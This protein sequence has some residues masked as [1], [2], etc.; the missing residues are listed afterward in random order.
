MAST[1][2]VTAKVTAINLKHRKATFQF[3]DGSTRTVA[4]RKD[5]D[6]SKRQVGEEVVIRTTETLAIFVQKPQCGIEREVQFRPPS[7]AQTLSR[8]SEES[9][10]A[11]RGRVYAGPSRRS[12][13]PL[14][15]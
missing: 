3:P 5:V 15:P 4:V 14:R 6:L 2:Q 10:H 7:A 1:V 9:Y 8:V 11:I 12:S 13:S